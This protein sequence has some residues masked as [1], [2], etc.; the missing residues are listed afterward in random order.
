MVVHREPEQDHEQQ[1]G[2]DRVD[3]AR[4]GEAEETAAEAVLE[5]EHQHAVGGGDGQQV[6]HDRLDCDHRRA[7]RD[8]H[9]REG[10]REHEPDDEGEIRRHLVRAVLPLGGR[11]GDARL[12]VRHGS[13]RR[14]HDL[15][16]LRER[17]IRGGVGAL[18][19]DR[20]RDA[21]DRGI[22]VDLDGDRLVHAARRECLL[23]EPLD[24]GLHLLG[25][26]VRSLDDDVGRQSRA[27]ERLLHPLVRLHG[28]ERLRE[29]VRARLDH[30]QLEGRDRQCDQEPA[31]ENGRH[32]RPAQDAV[33][34][35]APDSAVAVVAAEPADER[36]AAPVD[37]VAEPR[38]QRRQHG[39]RPDHRDRDH[40]DRGDREGLEDGVTCQEHAGH[41]RHHGQAGDEHG[42]AGRRGCGLERSAFAASRCPLLAFTLQVEE[43]VVDTDGE[44]DQEH[45][46]AGLVRHRDDVAGAGDDAEGREDGRQCEQQRDPGGDESAERDREDDE[47]DRQR[48]HPGLA[49][50][51]LDGRRERVDRAGHAELA[52]VELRVRR[53]SAGDL[54]EDRVELQRRLVGRAADLELD[55]RRVPVRGGLTGVNVLNDLELRQ[56]RDDIADRGREGGVG[57][58]EHAALDEDALRGGPFEAGVEDPVHAAGLTGAGGVGV[59]RLRPGRAEREGDENERQPPEGCGLPV[60]GAPATHPGRDVALGGRADTS[61][62][63]WRVWTSCSRR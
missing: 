7:E 60:V 30:L 25:L 57:R 17:G 52:D 61:V 54:G 8:E 2:D 39:Q 27:G 51:L 28:G 37:A 59:D 44:P 36:D 3:P 42:A 26:H 53:L 21:R 58:R 49:E 22:V 12:G 32:E 62:P 24:R 55:E 40:R 31:G 50:V 6:E 20:H 5:D 45:E 47:R 19:L 14:R 4:R 56:P 48:Q 38:Q 10:E 43:R 35:G 33:D 9:Q 41:R 13:D 29:R 16:Q 1:Q 46:R 34:D 18:A 15:P 63:P 11:T 23:A